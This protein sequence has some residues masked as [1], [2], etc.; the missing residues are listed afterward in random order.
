M[1]NA[2]LFTI[3]SFCVINAIFQ[4][5]RCET[6]LSTPSTSGDLQQQEEVVL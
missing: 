1:R 2:G 3:Y 6:V 5:G 4:A